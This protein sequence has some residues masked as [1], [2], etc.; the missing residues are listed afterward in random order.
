MG[1]IVNSD[2]ALNAWLARFGRT[3]AGQTVAALTDRFAVPPGAA[4]HVTL[5]GQRLALT[6]SD[7]GAATDGGDA[8]AA[9]AP[10]DD[11]FAAL[12][13]RDGRS[14]GGPGPVSGATAL[15]GSGVIPGSGAVPG[16][17]ETQTMTGREFLLGS[18]FHLTTD[19]KEPGA[20]RWTA[21]GRAALESFSGKD[22]G[23]KVDGE[24][25]TG[26]FGADWDA[27]R[28]LGGVALTHSIG[29][30]DLK[31]EGMPLG[32]DVESTVTAVN[33]YLRLQLTERVSAWGVAG[34]GGGELELTVK[35]EASG[36]TP[37]S[38]RTYRTDLT[39]TLGALGARGELV[40]PAESGGYGLALRGDAFWVR[41]ESDAVTVAGV[42]RLAASEG[43]ASRVRLTLEGSRR[44][45]FEGG[46][47]LTPLLEVG[48]RQDG[49][50]AETGTGLE[51]GGGLAY[52][53]RASGLSMDLRARTLVAHA[54]SG[55][56]EWGVSGAVKLQPGGAG[57]GLSLSLLPAFGADA[58]GDRIWS[59]RDAAALAPANDATDPK[60]RLEAEIGYGL[61][62]FGGGFTGT[63]YLGFGT[64]DT[65]R[66]YRLGW[67]LTRPAGAGA[68]AFTLEAIRRE[69]ANDDEPEH[70]IGFRA[71]A[72]W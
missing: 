65:E 7:T 14:D 45:D 41:T 33:P 72:R 24:V 9:A 30:G 47:A 17:A 2:P 1:T 11:A 28:W 57:R 51:L 12:A 68:F 10:D 18:S 6:A 63:P 59:A 3:V 56:R 42:G 4:S 53:D 22:G 49:G 64:S 21:W 37:A 44:I 16:S 48:L 15:P 46:G 62:A 70:G 19:G 52:A 61:P 71:T 43:E 34:Y 5:G 66:K 8:G 29:E 13:S 40:T 26:V 69:T 55:Y 32:Y 20:G 58:G 50:D 27:G 38:E 31:P 25:A 36:D 23:L 35:R 67:R 60:G 39:M 54:E